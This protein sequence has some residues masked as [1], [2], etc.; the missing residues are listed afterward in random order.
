MRT[1][2]VLLGWLLISGVAAS[3]VNSVPSGVRV[4]LEPSIS[5]IPLNQMHSWTVLLQTDSGEA[6]SDAQIQVN[7][8]MPA[9]DHGLATNPQITRYLGEGRYLLEGVR[10]HMPGEWLL[11]LEINHLQQLYRADITVNL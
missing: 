9:H 2:I 3:P 4:T 11:R 8:G 5:P 1:I 7:G 6:I 10:F